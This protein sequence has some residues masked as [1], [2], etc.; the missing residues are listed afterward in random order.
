MLQALE[1]KVKNC[2][3]CCKYQ[4]KRADPIL[5]SHLPELPWQKVGTDLF[6]W[7]KTTHLLIVNYYSR[8]I[9]ISKLSHLTVD[10]I[11]THTKSIFARHGIP[12]V[13]YS[14]NGPQFQSFV[15]SQFASAY[16]FN[17]ITS[18]PYFPQSN[19]KAERAVATIK[20]LLK[21]GDTYLVLLAYCSNPLE[22][23]FSPSQLLVSRTLRSTIPTVREQRKS[24][25]PDRELVRER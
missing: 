9:E 2:Y 15:Y 7:K 20:N 1:L 19:S 24:K 13:V 6:E 4:R 10:A 17:H 16:Q 5:P 21:K 25:V 22:I 8:Y 3:E 11:I 23:G 14:D 12:E 18:S